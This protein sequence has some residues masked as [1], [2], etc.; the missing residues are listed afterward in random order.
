MEQLGRSTI[1]DR[2]ALADVEQLRGLWEAIETEESFSLTR[3]E[4]DD[5][6]TP[7]RYLMLAQLASEAV[8]RWVTV[9]T[10]SVKGLIRTNLAYGPGRYV[11]LGHGICW[12]GLDHESWAR[13]GRSPIW[14]R[15]GSTEWGRATAAARA[16]TDWI[17]A[18]PPR[19]YW[20]GPGKPLLV[21]ALL[22][23]GGI[24][25]AA[26]TQIVDLIREIDSRFETSGIA[27]LTTTEG[28]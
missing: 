26:V 10:G 23:A 19:A 9:G 24:R 2:Q 6:A 3:E 7:K 17:R 16:L 15:F 14:L 28:V 22:P 12:L 11:N 1:D 4:A 21:P 8:D 5:I 18:T 27:P 20:E 25:E 13:Y